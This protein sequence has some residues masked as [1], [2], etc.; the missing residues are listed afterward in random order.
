MDYLGAAYPGDLRDTVDCGVSVGIPPS[1]SIS[2]LLDE[3]AEYVEAGYRR[4]KC[5]IEPGWDVEPI[6]AVRESWPD[7]LLQTDA[8]QAFTLAD[9]PVLAAM[10]PFDLLLVEQPL[11]ED[12]LMGH[13]ALARKLTTPVCLDESITSVAVAETA[14]HVEATSIINIKPGRVGSYLTAVRIHDLCRDRGIPVWCGGMLETGIG[15]AANVALAAL[16]GFTLPGDTSASSR[17]YAVD[18][19]PPFVLDDGRLHVPTGPGIGVEIDTDRIESIT[20]RVA[21]FG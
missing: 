3:V 18:V 8:N 6:R 17:Y 5:K 16:P 1:E 13:A 20:T 2:E 7:M 19:T 9:A 12:D 14:L 11:H 10:D 4:I 21:T 15:R